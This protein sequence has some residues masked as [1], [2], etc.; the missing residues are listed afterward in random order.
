MGRLAR[1][2]NPLLELLKVVLTAPLINE[3]TKYYNRIGVEELQ[4][5]DNTNLSYTKTMG[6]IRA[7]DRFKED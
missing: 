2:P 4:K 5:K 3:L 7:S 6:F 1:D